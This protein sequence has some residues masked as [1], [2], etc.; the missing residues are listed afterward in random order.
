MGFL[1][2]ITIISSVF[3]FNR[4]LALSSMLLCALSNRL[5]HLHGICIVYRYT[6]KQFLQFTNTH[7]PCMLLA[8]RKGRIYLW[9]CVVCI[10]IHILLRQKV[11]VKTTSKRQTELQEAIALEFYFFK[12]FPQ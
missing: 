10:Y 1:D 5:K 3:S 9:L 6:K 2:P 7:T 8:V 4:Q 11:Y 12:I